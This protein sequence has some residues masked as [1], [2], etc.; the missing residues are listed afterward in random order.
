MRDEPL[1]RTCEAII[2]RLGLPW[3]FTARALCETVAASRG[4]PVHLQPHPF[5]DGGT[6][7]LCVSTERAD[8]IFYE[9][10]TSALHQEHIILHELGH[11]ALGHTEVPA[12]ADEGLPL[13]TTHLDATRVLGILGRAARPGE[14]ERA[15]ELFAELVLQRVQRARRRTGEPE[16]DEVLDRMRD[17]LGA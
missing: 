5:P 15:A 6:S 16:P 4:R 1:Q 8:H 12:T 11:L 2:D 13:P 17:T 14:D 3:P 7:G 9:A 10:H